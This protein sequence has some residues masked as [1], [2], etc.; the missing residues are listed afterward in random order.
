MS[1]L[2]LCDPYPQRKP[3]RRS[4]EPSKGFL[5]DIRKDAREEADRND[6]DHQEGRISR[7]EWAERHQE[8]ETLRRATR[9]PRRFY[10]RD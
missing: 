2:G 3:E 10:E 6:A 1:E 5:S 4:V 9:N 7:L 8:L